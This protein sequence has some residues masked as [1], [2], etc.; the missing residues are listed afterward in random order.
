MS[1][2]NDLPPPQ[3]LGDGGRTNQQRCERNAIMRKGRNPNDS[4][5]RRFRKSPAAQTIWATRTQMGTG[6][7]L[8]VTATGLA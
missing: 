2:E 7:V 1:P 5:F 4:P 6:Q 8:L 3:G